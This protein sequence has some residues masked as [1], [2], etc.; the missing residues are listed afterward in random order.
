MNIVLESLFLRKPRIEYVSPPV[1]PIQPASASA[2]ST[3]ILN[4]PESCV[5]PA[6]EIRFGQ[7]NLITWAPLP[8]ECD[9][10]CVAGFKCVELAYSVYRS[11]TSDGS[12]DA[13][14]SGVRRMHTVLCTPGCYEARAVDAN[15]IE[16]GT[17]GPVCGDGSAP[18]IVPMPAVPGAT[19]FNLYR[20]ADFRNPDGVYQLVISMY[21]GEAFEAC[22]TG[23]YR[24]GFI[25]PDGGTPLSNP[26]C[27]NIMCTPVVCPPGQVWNATSCSCVPLTCP[28]Q[29]CPTGFVWDFTACM[30]VPCPVQPCPP[31]F[32]WDTTTCSCIPVGLRAGLI[33]YWKLDELSVGDTRLDSVG[34]H[35]LT[36]SVLSVE[37]A[38]PA[39]INGGAGPFQFLAQG[40]LGA[41][42]TRPD[43]VDLRGD[44]SFT[45]AG[46]VF[47]S[48]G[49]TSRCVWSKW[50]RTTG[51][52]YI[53]YTNQSA[54]AFTYYWCSFG[55]GTPLNIKTI[56]TIGQ[57]DFR[58]T[59]M[60]WKYLAI[61]WDSVNKIGFLKV[62]HDVTNP[63]VQTATVPVDNLV[64]TTR[65]FNLGNTEPY[66]YAWWGSLDEVGFWGRVLSDAELIQ[67]F[68]HGA[69]LPLGSF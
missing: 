38:S 55:D 56:D 10:G 20:T 21:S 59:P 32:G 5:P 6:P 27:L 17:S 23:C 42:L 61:G 18:I 1:C 69:G 54:D 34:T 9:E 39:I 45:M 13:V 12:F 14:I 26:L 15:G 11:A 24:V 57:G 62:V 29:S 30:C 31:G 33:A 3:F 52:E 58:M 64:G 43:D 22:V 4:L 65:D 44:K 47:S 41:A 68:N 37:S 51:G 60:D 7:N 40:Q 36:D 49:A 16:T 19:M 46:W 8:G 35:D 48:A 25:T 53:L 50:N 2:S 63:L 28:E 67:L 66:N